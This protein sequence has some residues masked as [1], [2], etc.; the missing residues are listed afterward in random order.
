MRWMLGASVRSKG[1]VV[2]LGIGVLILGVTQFGTMS[3]DVLPEFGPPTVEVQTEALG[4]SAE[5]V[6]QLVTTP[7]EQ[8]LLNGVAFL[9]VIRSE[10]LPGL[11]RIELIFEDGTA[12][13]RA[14]QVVNERLTQAQGL[15][16]V[17]QKPQMLQPASS[18]SRVMMVRLS[19]KQQ[20]LIDMSLLARWTIRPR[21]MGVP[22]VANVAVWGQREQQ[23]QVQVDPSRLQA[24]GATLDDVV[25]TT[26]NA[27]WVSPLTFLEASTPGA[28]GFYDTPSQ[29]IGVEHIQPIKTPEDLAKVI[30]DQG[31]AAAPAEAARAGRPAPAPAPK[32][33]GDV[34]TI[35][36]DHQPLI[37]DA[38]F[39]DGPGL[40]IVIEKLPEANV[41]EVTDELEDALEGLRPG[42]AGIDVDTSFFKPAR[43]VADSQANLRTALLVGLA[44]AGLALVLL[45]IDLRAAFVTVAAVVVS[46]A[47]AVVVLELRGASVNAVVLGGLAL[48]L[49]VLIDDAVS[50]VDGIRRRPEGR[51]LA[52]AVMRVRSPLAYGTAILLLA[53]V[54]LYVLR[55]EAGAFLP[56]LATTYALA[57]LV[58][59]V[60]SLTLTP[61]LA[62]VVLTGSE[63]RV[64]PVLRRIASRYDSLS[65]RLERA[66]RAG[67]VIGGFLLLMGLLVLPSLERGS[68]IVPDFKDRDVLIELNGAPGTSLPE[69]SRIAARAA[70]EIRG[71]DGIDNVGGHVG[72]AVL[73]DQVVGVNS[74]ELWVS[75]V[76]DV[77]YGRTVAAVEAVVNGYPGID[78]AVLTYPRA[79]IDDE[80]RR[81]EGVKGRDLTVRVF[82]STDLETLRTTADRVRAAI[83][84]VEGVSDPVTDVAPQEP[85]IQVKVDLDRAQAL[86]IKPGDVRRAAAT[87]LSGIRAGLLFE[88][89]KVFDVMVWGTPDTRGNVESVRQVLI[90]K[91]GGGQ[92]R[93][94]EVADVAVAPSPNVIR[95]EAASRAI[96]VGVNVS[97]R[98][99][100]AVADDIREAVR[101]LDY[102][103]EYH[104]ELLT[105]FEQDQASRL[106]FIVLLVGAAIAIFL[107][108]QVVTGSWTMAAAALLALAA[109]LSGGLVAARLDGDPV[110]IGTL[111]G[112]LAVLGLAARHLAIFL[113][114]AHALEDLDGRPFGSP[115]ATEVARDRLVPTIASTIAIVLICLPLIALG[116]RAGL[117][118]V[119][120]MAG[121][122]VGGL[123]TTTL[124][125]LVVVPAL[126]RRFGFRPETGREQYDTF[127]DLAAAGPD[128]LH[129]PT[130]IDA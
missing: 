79:R 4:L 69:M 121:V 9:D 3:K 39:T 70:S 92:V 119:S 44:L 103:L 30:L 6:E 89:Q 18:T 33:L 19:S 106:V 78:R 112:F 40:L 22:G 58:S 84:A 46:L 14:R 24:G 82:G 91:P 31:A 8:D 25:R 36:V 95:H 122:V 12:I 93:L 48:A 120:P 127:V 80:L 100:N 7:L 104:A 74:G 38:V 111:V 16:A 113:R 101:D 68:S 23:L 1:L 96:D 117:E 118:I 123:L 87:M 126:Y 115:L 26:G 59:L 21:L 5:E 107:L 77:D 32:R 124:C 54:P 17:A 50:T 13:A 85:E 72:R 97:G 102:P 53:L 56:P 64:S 45:M 71:L 109:A 88:Q 83:G 90:D 47:G 10:S 34:T 98:D 51:G 66:P 125:S 60:V 41:V 86:G 76:P 67:L 63:P 42:L 37:G 61:A 55:G 2:A 49:F 57:V 75:L 62:A 20:S 99:I 28:G 43:Y 81:P 128:D 65:S 129:A 73:G 130:K 35:A 29:R 108:L 105:G 15:P 27:L 52:S 11:S 110:T 114:A 94:A 116:G